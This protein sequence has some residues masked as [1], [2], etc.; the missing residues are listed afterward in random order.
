MKKYKLS[1][2]TGTSTIDVVLDANEHETPEDILRRMWS[3]NIVF[4]NNTDGSALSINMRNIV[5]VVIACVE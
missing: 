1:F 2:T 5:S 3:D 4:F